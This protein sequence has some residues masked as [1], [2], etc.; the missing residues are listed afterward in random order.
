MSENY[1]YD[2]L[3]EFD[4]IF[5]DL[6]LTMLHSDEKHRVFVYGTLM[7][8]MRNHARLEVDSARLISDSAHT[9]GTVIMKSRETHGGYRAPVV[10][11]AP[12]SEPLSI[13]L[14][15]VYE[16][17]NEL[18]G[19]LDTFEG[20]PEVY[21]REKVFVQAE[22]MFEEMWMYFY[23]TDLP[24]NAS[25]ESITITEDDRFGIFHYRWRGL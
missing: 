21:M 22:N 7:T 16:V 4:V 23:V 24:A 11:H 8:G 5:G 13:I 6:N 2:D 25:Q 12:A 9:I 1:I 15:E 19:T 3:D 17:S 14:G 10:M 18:L 20:H